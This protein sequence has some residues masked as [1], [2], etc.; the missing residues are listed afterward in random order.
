MYYVPRT[1]LGTGVRVMKDMVC[2]FEK[3]K[4]IG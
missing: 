3:L 4:S 2:M 1:V